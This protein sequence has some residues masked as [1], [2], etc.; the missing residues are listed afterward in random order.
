MNS[1]LNRRAYFLMT[2]H[3]TCWNCALLFAPVIAVNFFPPPEKK[4][5]KHNWALSSHGRVTRQADRG[6]SLNKKGSQKCQVFVHFYTQ[7]Y[8][9]TGNFTCIC[10]CIWA[11]ICTAFCACIC[12][13]RHLYR[14]LF[15]QSFVGKGICRYRHL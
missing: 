3:S 15:V 11:G 8:I 2:V 5:E 4:S 13:Y 1:T 6:Q 7:L 9:H 12:W 14:H 10:T